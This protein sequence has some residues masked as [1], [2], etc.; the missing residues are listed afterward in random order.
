MSEY[1]PTEARQTTTRTRAKRS[2][3][4]PTCKMVVPDR[5]VLPVLLQDF[6]PACLLQF[7]R[8]NVP[9]LMETKIAQPMVPTASQVT[10]RLEAFDPTPLVHTDT[11]RHHD[12][13]PAAGW[14]RARPEGQDPDSRPFG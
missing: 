10:D 8:K 2:W 5:S 9:I 12:R 3:H 7:L 4:C 13:V 11:L 6:C 14:P 1:E